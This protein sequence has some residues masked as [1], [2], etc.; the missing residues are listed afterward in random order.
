M[1]TL[2]RVVELEDFV[3]FRIGLVIDIDVSSC[4]KVRAPDTGAFGQ[5][6]RQTLVKMARAELAGSE[7]QIRLGSI[8][9]DRSRCARSRRCGFGH[10]DHR[11]SRVI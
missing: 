11:R 6:R 4:R 9:S 5:A 1:A 7:R 3:R 2:S 10:D 8:P